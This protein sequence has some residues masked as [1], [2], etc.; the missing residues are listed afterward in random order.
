MSG[1][2][3]ERDGKG[4]FATKGNGV[5]CVPKGAAGGGPVPAAEPS[6]GM[7]QMRWNKARSDIFFAELGELCNISAALRAAGIMDSKAAHREKDRD[8]EF[9][10]RFE[11]A[12]AEGYSRLELEMLE[13]MRFGDNRPANQGVSG[14]RQREIPTAVAMQ[15][16]KLHHAK[17][18][19]LAAPSR[20]APRK[21]QRP[22]RGLGSL[23]AEIDAVLSQINL[24]FGGE[25]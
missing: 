16:L 8:P 2:H 19:G 3:N 9:A 13:R 11:A 25:G 4:K 23:R 24:R 6:I 1:R 7:R 12:I 21:P 14:A 5:E 17:V 15:L 10:R 18:K 20:A 22:K